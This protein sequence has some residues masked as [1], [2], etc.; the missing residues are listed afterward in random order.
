MEFPDWVQ[1]KENKHYRHRS[2]IVEIIDV[3]KRQ[4]G[5]GCRPYVSRKDRKHMFVNIIFMLP[6]HDLASMDLLK[7]PAGDILIALNF[8]TELPD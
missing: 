3:W 6:R 5:K 8:L 4:Y 1:V 7:I 2:G